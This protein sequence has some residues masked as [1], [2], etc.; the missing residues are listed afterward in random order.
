MKNNDDLNKWSCLLE[1]LWSFP[2]YKDAI[3]DYAYKVIECTPESV[4]DEREDFSTF[5]YFTEE[6]LS[7]FYT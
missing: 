1:A 2:Q 7:D 6:N 4:L 5:E 3:D